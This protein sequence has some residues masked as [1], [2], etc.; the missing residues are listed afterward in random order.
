MV[1]EVLQLVLLTLVPGL[2]LRASIPYGILLLPVSWPMVVL[3]CVV[4]NALL[5][6]LVYLLLTLCVEW[7]RK[8]PFLDRMYQKAI[9]HTQKKVHPYVE[10]YG[11]WGLAL[12]VGIPLPGSGSY[13][14]ALAAYVLGLDAKRFAFANL[15]GVI[16]AAIAVTLITLSGNE[17]FNLFIKVI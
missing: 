17:L 11:V 12:F 13:T 4:T 5:G 14:G 3:I 15:I 6:P 2:E 16:L 9:V 8:I 10:R 1:T 7:L